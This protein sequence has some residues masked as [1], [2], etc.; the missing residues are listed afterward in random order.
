MNFK[1]H[2]NA[3]IKIHKH[4][5]NVKFLRRFHDCVRKMVGEFMYQSMHKS[6]IQIRA[7]GL[8]TDYEPIDCK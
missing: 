8:Q 4:I 1:I 5:N 7:I 3:N 6:F 2:S